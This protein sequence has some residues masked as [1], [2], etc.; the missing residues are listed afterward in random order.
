LTYLYLSNSILPALNAIKRFI[1]T[2]PAWAFG[3]VLLAVTVNTIYFIYKHQISVDGQSNHRVNGKSVITRVTPGGAADRAGMLPGDTLLTV[4]GIDVHEWSGINHDVR[5][6]DTCIYGVVRNGQLLNMPVVFT[7][8]YLFFYGFTITIYVILILLSITSLYLVYKKPDDPTVRLFFA[9]L[10]L[11]AISQNATFL[12]FRDPLALGSCIIFWLSTCL[13]GPVLI[14]FHLIFPRTAKIYTRFR[15]LPLL[16]YIAGIIIFLYCLIYYIPMIYGRYGLFEFFSVRRIVLSWLSLTYL[17]ALAIVFY[18]FITIKDTLSR[19]QLRLVIIGSFFGIYTAVMLAVAPGFMMHI[20][21]GYPY[22]VPVVQGTGG[23]IMIAFILIA[24]FRY[25]IW[26]ISIIIRKALQYAAASLFIILTYLLIIYIVNLLISKES[27]LYR[28]LSLAA[29]VIIFLV[30]RDRLQRWIDRLF[31]RETY[32]SAAVVSDFEEEIAGAFRIEDLGPRILDRMDQ[33]F[34]FK[35]IL[36]FLKKEDSHY[37][38]AFVMGNKDDHPKREFQINK[39]FENKLLKQKVF[40]PGELTDSPAIPDPGQVELVVPMVKD[41]S[42]F[43]FFLCG[44]KKSEKSY[45][46]QDIR[47]LSLIAKRVIALFQTAALYQKD[48]DRQLMLERERARISQDMHDDV[49]ASLTRISILS[50]LAKNKEDV[51]GETKQWLGQISDT[52]RGVMEEMSQIIWALNPKNDTL[53]GLVAYLRRF[54]NEFLEPTT[55][56]CYFDLPETLPIRALTV[57][58]R[59]NV[60]LVVREAL[61]NV[62]KHSGAGKVEIRFSILN[63]RFSISITDD[64]KGFDPGMLEFPGNGLVNMKKRMADIGGEIVIRS[65]KGF[66]T[67]IELMVSL[68]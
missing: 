15:K 19:N 28:F 1:R 20:S 10:Q 60:Y 56:N 39:E 50:D 65:D 36:L 58:A 31:H 54:A 9:Y 51:T 33:I 6:G 40:S 30:L 34:H 68:K 67:E 38:P 26:D 44:P 14:H 46:M 3:L 53:E 11:F 63:S 12:L 61:H 66:G 57:E 55:I 48:L 25:R 7:S 35:S 23:L 41:G 62:V 2:I 64:G 21:A 37:E 52:S 29:S 47:V 16:I 49:G 24:I 5:V 43:G 42:P 17:F 59:R 27:D 18:Q 32:D 22:F 4:D 8:P 13:I 45:S